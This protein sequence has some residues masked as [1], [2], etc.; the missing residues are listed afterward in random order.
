[1]DAE[2]IFR[3]HCERNTTTLFKGFLMILEDLQKEHEIHFGKLK[4][5]LPKEF[6]PLIEQADYLDKEKVQHLRKRTLD[7][8]NEAIRSIEGGF[9]NFTIDFEFKKIL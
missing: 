9:E 2:N 8:G 7:I 3:K 6:L 5:S 4:K 1:M